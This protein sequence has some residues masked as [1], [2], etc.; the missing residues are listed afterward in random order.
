MSKVY[1]KACLDRGDLAVLDPM[2]VSGPNS[3]VYYCCPIHNVGVTITK[4][5]VELRI[6]WLREK[7]TDLQDE[8]SK[9]W[10]L[11]KKMD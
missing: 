7:A 6:S 10:M 5:A 2:N 9:L 3:G 1:C 4:R 11:K 8:A